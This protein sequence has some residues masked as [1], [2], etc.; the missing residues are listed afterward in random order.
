LNNGAASTPTW[1]KG[2]SRTGV[3]VVKGSGRRMRFA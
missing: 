1:V 2:D 3:D